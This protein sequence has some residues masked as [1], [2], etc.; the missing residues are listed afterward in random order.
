MVRSVEFLLSN[1]HECL[2]YKFKITWNIKAS[3]HII[4][5]E[6]T[7]RDTGHGTKFGTRDTG[8]G[9]RDKIRDTGH[10]TRD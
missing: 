2:K 6:S 7:K 1:I 4:G 9:T 8:H 5:P 10:G 3:K